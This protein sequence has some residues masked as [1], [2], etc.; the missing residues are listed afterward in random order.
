MNKYFEES[1]LRDDSFVLLAYS[2]VLKKQAARLKQT[3]KEK[4]NSL[5]LKKEKGGAE[6]THQPGKRR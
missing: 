4:M 6:R 2:I 1:S 3:V 5:F